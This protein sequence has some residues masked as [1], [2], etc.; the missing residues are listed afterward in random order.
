MNTAIIHQ[1]I[2]SIS[3]GLSENILLTRFLLTLVSQMLDAFGIWHC[4]TWFTHSGPARGQLISSSGLG[5]LVEIWFE[6]TSAFSWNIPWLQDDLALSSLIYSYHI[7]FSIT[8]SSNLIT[9]NNAPWRTCTIPQISLKICDDSWHDNRWLKGVFLR[10]V[11]SNQLLD[12]W[13]ACNIIAHFLHHRRMSYLCTLQLSL[14]DHCGRRCQR[15]LLCQIITKPAGYSAWP[16]KWSICFLSVLLHRLASSAV[17]FVCF[18]FFTARF[19]KSLLGP[20]PSVLP[21]TPHWSLLQKPYSTFG[22]SFHTYHL[23]DHIT[24][25]IKYA[26]FNR[27]LARVGRLY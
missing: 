1:E 17:V 5:L 24:L 13:L 12:A 26:L 15:L 2:W 10:A 27:E 6:H 20:Q 9:G 16:R 3:S 21:P 7:G 4:L 11:G 8:H 25:Y 18:V 23:P 19:C 14:C 22:T